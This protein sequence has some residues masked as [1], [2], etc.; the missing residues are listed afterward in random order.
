MT[1]KLFYVDLN[2]D[3]INMLNNIP[4]L[5]NTPV[6]IIP[7]NDCVENTLNF[8]GVITSNQATQLQLQ[9]CT[10]L[11]TGTSQILDLFKQ[12]YPNFVFLERRVSFKFLVDNLPPNKATF[13]GLLRPPGTGHAVIFVKDVNNKIYL[14]DRQQ[15]IK[16]VNTDIDKYLKYLNVDTTSLLVY[17]ARE[18]ITTTQSSYKF[19]KGGKKKHK[20]NKSRKNKSRKN[21]SRKNKSRKNKSRKIKKR[22]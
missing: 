12:R 13:G 15:N 6:S 14:V 16:F 7:R 8:L 21:K 17:S 9:S 4:T 20:K 19:G 10:K 18:N 11:E 3:A 5:T 2:S 1:E 22:L